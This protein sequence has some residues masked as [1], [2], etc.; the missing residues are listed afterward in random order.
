VTAY[1]DEPGNTWTRSVALSRYLGGS[2]LIALGVIEAFPLDKIEEPTLFALVVHFA[3]K[4]SDSTSHSLE[5]S[6][7]ISGGG[8]VIQFGMLL[9]LVGCKSETWKMG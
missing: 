5:V 6:S 2:Q 7:S 9:A 8:S 4:G 1:L 3:V